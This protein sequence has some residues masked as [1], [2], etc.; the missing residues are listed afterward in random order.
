[1]IRL[2]VSGASPDRQWRRPANGLRTTDAMIV[3]SE[4]MDGCAVDALRQR[5]EVC[6]DPELADRQGDLLSMVV[7]C[8]ALIVRNR[9]QVTA[10]MLAAAP[11]LACVGRLGVG[12]DNIDLDSCASRG[13]T[14]YPATGANNRSVAEYVIGTAMALLRGAYS[15]DRRMIAGEWPRGACA[16]REIF[17]KALG[18]VGFG[19]I[20][21]ETAGLAA[22][23]GMEV[24]ACDPHLPENAS[25]WR[26]ARKLDMP[27]LLSGS[28]VI[29]IH[30]PFS[31]TTRHLINRRQLKRIKPGAVIIN[32]S[33]GG[34]VDEAALVDA[35]KEGRLGGRGRLTCSKT[36]RSAPWTG[37]CLRRCRKFD[38]DSAHCR[39]HRG[40][41]PAG[42][43]SHRRECHGRISKTRFRAEAAR[44]PIQCRPKL[45]TGLSTA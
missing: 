4:F 15:E 12:L 11:R 1:M 27:E 37:A 19:S 2:N 32:S 40:V 41:Q 7:S 6:Y 13:V 45:I 31:E 36:S 20:G 30:V 28:D 16:G 34:V 10:G 42:Q 25:A 18:L 3:I 44:G 43:R 8:R 26:L 9:T 39:C 22:A 17:G 24:F 35:L 5:H 29:S 38:P 33:R 14:V 21:Q 23:L